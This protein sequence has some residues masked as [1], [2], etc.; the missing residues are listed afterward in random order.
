MS[1]SSIA[2]SVSQFFGSEKLAVWS[3][4]LIIAGF[5]PAI[6]RYDVFGNVLR[7]SDYGDHNSQ[8]G[9]EFDHY[10]IPKPHGGSDDVSNL[11]PLHW[12][13][14]ARLSR[15]LDAVSSGHR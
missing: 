5:D 11:R 4:G 9:W 1:L 8:W 2:G 7:Y 12:K 13:V 6:W 15:P 10:P 14:S 3:K